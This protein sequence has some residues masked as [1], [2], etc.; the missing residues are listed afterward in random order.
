MPIKALFL[1]RDGVINIDYG[2]IYRPDQIAFVDGI[3]DLCGAALRSGFQIIVVTN[4]AGVARGHYTEQQVN[5]LHEW[6]KARFEERGVPILAVY[7]CPYHAEAG[8]GQYRV[9]SFD[10]KPKPGMFLRAKAEHD[11]DMAASVL[12]GD[13][14]SDIEAGRAAGVATLV[15]FEP[16]E[17]R[18]LCVADFGFRA[19]SLSA[20]AAWLAS[21]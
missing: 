11:I 2:Y 1:D 20:I 14:M 6:L 21:R 12:V 4:Q 19:G 18:E 7:Y 10:R 13:K 16:A 9:D 3:F 8:T 17:P 15:L 5:E